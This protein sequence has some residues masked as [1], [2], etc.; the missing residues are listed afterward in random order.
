[1]KEKVRDKFYYL[2][3]P[4]QTDNKKNTSSQ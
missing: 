1:M 2:T 3:G 4:I